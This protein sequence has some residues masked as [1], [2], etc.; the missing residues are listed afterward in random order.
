M[1]S[2]TSVRTR[3]RAQCVSFQGLQISDNVV[4]ILIGILIEKRNMRGV[5]IVLLDF[6]SGLR[7]ND[8]YWP[9]ASRKDT[10]KSSM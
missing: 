5:R 1:L 6:E 7:L 8:R 10:L 9:E 2:R 4:D 3:K